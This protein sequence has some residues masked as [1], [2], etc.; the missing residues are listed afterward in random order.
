MGDINEQ[1]DAAVALMKARAADLTDQHT[2]AYPCELAGA[3]TIIER[4]HVEAAWALTAQAWSERQF[5]REC[6]LDTMNLCALA[7]S[8][9]PFTP[10]PT[11]G[12]E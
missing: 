8:V 10:R 9:L 12:G 3:D 1:I 11:E 2:S 6:L 5:R 4:M 7:L